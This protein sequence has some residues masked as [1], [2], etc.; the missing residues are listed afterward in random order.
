MCWRV[1]VEQGRRGMDRVVR[2]SFMQKARF[3]Q[4]FQDG[5]GAVLA[6][7]GRR[8]QVEGPGKA[9]VLRKE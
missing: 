1:F 4:R 9:A 5:K 3:E 7:K 2:G 6:I 8:F